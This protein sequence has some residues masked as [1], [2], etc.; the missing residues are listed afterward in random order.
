MQFRTAP[1]SILVIIQTSFAFNMASFVTVIRHVPHRILRGSVVLLTK[2]TIQNG[3]R[4]RTAS[5]QMATRM[6][7]T[8]DVE[9]SHILNG[10]TRTKIRNMKVQSMRET[11]DEL[12]L[13]SSG[14]RK[15]LLERLLNEVPASLRKRYVNSSKEKHHQAEEEINALS[16]DDEEERTDSLNDRI[17]SSTSTYILQ[18]DGGSRGN[19]GIAGAGMVIYNE[20][21]R[22]VWYGR[23]FVGDSMTNNVAEYSGLLIGLQ[24][25]RI[26]GAEHI[27]VQGD[28][29]LVVKQIRGEYRCKSKLLLPYHHAA[30]QLVSQFQSFEIRHIPRAQNGRA[31][32]LANE[33]MDCRD[34]NYMYQFIN[35]MKLGLP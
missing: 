14:L 8:D 19:P 4:C 17:L 7:S 27:V 1:L 25:A 35:P 26:L 33:A 16:V 10:L 6:M 31:D 24:C 34:F 32:N 18:F 20:S 15:D 9:R 21:G 30:R 22:E 5:L 28:S 11:L 2:E 13:S 23:H 3:C 12:G 29:D